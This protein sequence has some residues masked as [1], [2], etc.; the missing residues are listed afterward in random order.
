VSQYEVRREVWRITERRDGAVY[1]TEFVEVKWIDMDE[2]E[3]PPADT[4]YAACSGELA[5]EA[6]IRMKR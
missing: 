1:K 4:I 2:A 6:N 3:S 5:R